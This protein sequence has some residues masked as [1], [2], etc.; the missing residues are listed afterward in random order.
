[1]IRSIFSVTGAERAAFL[2]FSGLKGGRV[3][4]ATELEFATC[5]AKCYLHQDRKGTRLTKGGRCR[6]FPYWSYLLMNN[7]EELYV[8]GKHLLGFFFPSGAKRGWGSNFLFL[9]AFFFPF[10]SLK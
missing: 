7:T 1:M 2:A 4:L 6:Y 8:S 9:F 5:C 10:N 3:L